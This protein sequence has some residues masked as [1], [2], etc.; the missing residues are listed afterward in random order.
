MA[1]ETTI[2]WIYDYDQGL[3]KVQAEKKP[4]LLDFYKKG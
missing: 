2:K 3:E 1:S 4:M